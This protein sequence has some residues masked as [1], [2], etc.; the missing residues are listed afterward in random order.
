MLF[1]G[2]RLFARCWARTPTCWSTQQ[3][4]L[5]GACDRGW[6]A[7]RGGGDRVLRGA[8]SLLGTGADQ[9]GGRHARRHGDWPASRTASSLPGAR[10]ARPAVDIIQP[11]ILYVGGIG[12]TMRI[13]RMAATKSLPVTPHAAN[14]AGSLCSPCTCC[15][16][17]PTLVSTLSSRSRRR[18]T[19]TSST[20]CSATIP[21]RSSTGRSRC[22]P[23]PAGASRSSQSGRRGRAIK[24]A[25]EPRH[26]FL[27]MTSRPSERLRQPQPST[28]SLSNAKADN[29]AGTG[30]R[31]VWDQCRSIYF[32]SE[33]R[34]SY[35]KQ[36]PKQ[37]ISIIFETRDRPTRWVSYHTGFDGSHRS[38]DR[39]S[40][41]LAAGEME[42]ALR[43]H[44][45]HRERATARLLKYVGGTFAICSVLMAL[46]SCVADFPMHAGLRSGD[47]NS[48]IIVPNSTLRYCF[49]M[50]LQLR[51]SIYPLT[52][53]E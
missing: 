31:Q 38:R 13:G 47:S 42:A 12:R 33:Y 9:G 34:V 52:R 51:R 53:I 26:R 24:R 5:A 35:R 4:L 30:C 27:R 15:R 19:I 41:G 40:V 46:V 11:D 2:D 43:H 22:R 39:S 29:N 49:G 10:S 20:A 23:N 6:P 18:T 25:S 16:P 14:S 8:L 28:Q 21:T 48:R 44:R 50:H 7:A 1:R 45:K 37:T 32:S 17:C 36:T 3:R